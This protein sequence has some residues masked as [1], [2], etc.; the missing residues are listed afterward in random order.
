MW[1]LESVTELSSH[2]S[3]EDKTAALDFKAIIFSSDNFGK[4]VL[5]FKCIKWRPLF[6]KNTQFLSLALGGKEEV[7]GKGTVD[8]SFEET[9][10]GNGGI[11]VDGGASW[12][13]SW[14]WSK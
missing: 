3:D 7:P 13:T 6:K 5:T 1:I 14:D 10:S 2:D 9:K 11:V 8:V 4:I 12:K